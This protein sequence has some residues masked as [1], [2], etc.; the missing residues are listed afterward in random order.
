MKPVAIYV[1]SSQDLHNVSCEAQA[2]QIR[3]VVKKNGEEIYRVFS[4]KAL[5]STRDVRPEFDEMIAL[6]TSKSPQFN[7]IYCLDTSR[8]G[9]DQHQTQVLLWQLRKKH[10]IE[11]IFINMPH[12]G[13]YLDPVFET[14]MSAFDQLHSQQS[15]VK[16]VASMKQNIMNG[17]R[18]GGRAP[19][20]Y[21]LKKVELGK[22]RSGKTI[23][24][25]L[26]EPDPETSPIIKEYFER[27][28]KGE[29]RMSILDD[30]YHRRIPS[31]SGKGKWGTPSVK[32]MED[33][34]D[35]YLG[36][37]VF[38]RH[39]ERIKERGKFCG[40]LHG[41]KWRPREEWVITKNTHEAI[42]T[43]EI[44]RVIREI[45]QKRIR[46]TPAS[47]KR[48]YAVSGI[49]KCALCGSNYTGDR[50][51]YRCN[52]TTKPGEKCLNNDISQAKLESAIFSLINKQ[53]LNFKNIKCFIDRV[54]HRFHS[55]HSE[56]KSLK[57]KLIR[58]D[59]E[60][61]KVM[62][63]YR[64]GTIDEDEIERELLVL[65]EQ[66]KFLVKSLQEIRELQE[67]LEVKDA[68]VIE[69]IKN[70]KE[71]VNQ[72]DPKLRKMVVHSLFEEIR[73]YPKEGNPWNRF[74]E[75]KGIHLPLTRVKMASPTGFEPVLSA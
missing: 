68:E 7:K 1:R 33:N 3:E 26:L 6:A 23:T 50:G 47:A 22:H 8:F 30:F 16:G 46:E 37:T 24:K 63:L 42:I 20:G 45:K 73:I 25:T 27:R 36:H 67:S 41:M 56:E 32:A 35:V 4:D 71:E 5:S 59:N 51:M 74:L 43:E 72:S 70:F 65:Q 14:I 61:R 11:V 29:T 38:N 64:L 19:F 48:T 69:V 58:I 44:G 17:F 60:I 49:M 34:V 57:S 21:R 40:Y 2:E 75:I 62:K 10:G 52:S 54:K 28:A 55:D 31:P 39:N 13:T 12:T 15:K 9:R 18:A 66:K 53:I